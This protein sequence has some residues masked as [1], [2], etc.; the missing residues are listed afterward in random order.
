MKLLKVEANMG[1][2][3]GDKGEFM[4]IDKIT[5]EDLLR[6]ANLTL[7]GDEIAFDAY[8][9]KVVKHLAHQ[10]IYKSVVQKLQSL[11]ERRKEFIDE[12][13]RLYLADYE[14]YRKE[15]AN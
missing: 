1:F 6:L 12:S 9:E 3:L 13:E 8:D 2:F 15:I 5:K 4:E 7:H 10:V 14:K 11:R